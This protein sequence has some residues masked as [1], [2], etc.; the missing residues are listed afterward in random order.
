[1]AILLDNTGER[2]YSRAECG[3]SAKTKRRVAGGKKGMNRLAVSLAVIL[4]S[5]TLSLAW[6]SSPSELVAEAQKPTLYW[7]VWYDV[8]LTME[9]TKLGL[10]SRFH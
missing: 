4:I 8:R 5:V 1:M 7:V 9:T 6:S 2:G 10:L 3:I